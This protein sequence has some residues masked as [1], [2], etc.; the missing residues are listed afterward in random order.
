MDSGVL[1]PHCE[2]N[3]AHQYHCGESLATSLVSLLLHEP[4]E[5]L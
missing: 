1:H 5:W 2:H 3:Y 4:S